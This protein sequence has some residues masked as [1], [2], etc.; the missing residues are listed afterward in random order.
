MASL[1]DDTR[2]SLYSDK[3]KQ[4]VADLE[5]GPLAKM[6]GGS[7]LTIKAPIELPE[8]YNEQTIETVLAEAA[9]EAAAAATDDEEGE[10]ASA[11]AQE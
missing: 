10:L 8:E 6:W 9:D 1:I 2:S 11:S 7:G 5:P 4:F 3:M